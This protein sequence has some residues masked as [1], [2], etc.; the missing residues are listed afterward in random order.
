MADTTHYFTS[1]FPVRYSAVVIAPAFALILACSADSTTAPVV[2]QESREVKSESNY[3][4]SITPEDRTVHVQFDRVRSTGNESVSAFM[5][6]VFDS[7]DAVGATRLVLDLSGT[8]G[9]DAFLAVPLVKGVLAREQL[10]RRGGLIVIV[11]PESFSPN[12]NTAKLLQQYA[13]PIF[14]KHPIS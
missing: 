7:A 14:V 2:R 8:K 9:G 13:Q 3:S 12:Q 11:G 1:G 6:R 4:F 5:Q 10:S